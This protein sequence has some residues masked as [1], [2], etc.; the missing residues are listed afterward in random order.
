MQS[1]SGQMDEFLIYLW[2]APE[3]PDPEANA[4]ALAEA[5]FAVVDWDPARLDILKRHG[6]KAMVHGPFS[7]DLFRK[8]ASEKAVWGY[9]LGDE[10]YPEDKFAP[11]AEQLRT[12]ERIDPAHMP[13]INMLSTTGD[14]L[15]TYMD[16]V[17]PPLLSFDYYQWW[18]GTD[19]YF[20][21]LEGFREAAQ[22]AHVP[23]AACFEVSANPA[24][25]R[26]DTGYLPDNPRKLRQSVYTT[27]A[28][29]AKGIEWYSAKMLFEPKSARLT[30]AGRDVAALN[31]EIKGIGSVL[32][33]LR[34]IDVFQTAPLPAATRTPPK[35]YWIHVLAEEGRPG[36]VQGMLKDDHGRDY[37]LVAN[38]DY[39]DAQ[40]VNVRLQ[41]KW[42]GI[43]PWNKPK[44]YSYAIEQFNKA[45]ADWIPV[46]SSSSTGFN[47]V[48]GAGDG[49][50][51]RI[52]TKVTP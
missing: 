24:V 2:N 22:A 39:R 36:L 8:L 32:V 3:D 7:E 43:A 14:F 50:L 26:G 29:G 45:K 27:L 11:I 13:F 23:L 1:Q 15:R 21:K 31:N 17:R 12:I 51:F 40:A 5:G 28:Y 37:L 16:T 35:D 47:F 44:T 10:P 4:K 9:H 48:I 20:E 49:E 18:W 41:S 30:P 34:S 46:S 33:A 19:R 52:A 25:E 38:R 42:L 6:L